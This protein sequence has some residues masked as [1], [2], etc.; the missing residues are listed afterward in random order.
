MRRA[1]R[2]SGAPAAERT[3]AIPRKQVSVTSDVAR[4]SILGDKERMWEWVSA[5]Q[6]EEVG[7]GSVEATGKRVSD[8]IHNEK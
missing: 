1:S 7:C 4:A 3:L 8:A 5:R 6:R 2:G